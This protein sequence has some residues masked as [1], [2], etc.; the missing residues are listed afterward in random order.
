MSEQEK[1][2]D[3]PVSAT[4]TGITNL[5][6]KQ[7]RIGILDPSDRLN[8]KKILITGSSSGLGLATAI[9][10]A[11]LG[12]VVIMAVRSGIPEKM[13]EVKRKSGSD[14]VFIH[15]VDLSDFDS[16]HKLVN[17]IK[18]QYGQLDVVIC[19]AA[20]VAKKGRKTKHGQEQMF[21]INYLAKFLFINLLLKNDCINTTGPN[22]SRIIFVASES[23]RNPREFNWTDFGKYIPHSI[24]KTVELYG[25]YKLLLV[26]F[27]H[28][29]SH[30]LN[31][32][33]TNIS[34][35]SLCPGPVNS[36]IAREA[37]AIFK[38]LLKLV[39]GI[40]FRSPKKAS[41]PLVYL[42]ASKDVEGK[43]FDYLF[44]MERK[45][46]DE[47]ASDKDNGKKLWQLSEELLGALGEKI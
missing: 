21:T 27:A 23:H 26:S 39:F 22:V 15:N 44:L 33:K 3:N 41:E 31:A 43:P 18:I 35:F 45:T 30:R 20:I 11:K 40:F 47:K 29:L 36:N 8:G 2:Y 34:V 25:Y 16:I 1:K 42:T 5:F 37:P 46:I 9:E 32:D 38:P 10:L 17:E 7:E 13:E 14:Q 12:A 24:G 6:K 19:N 4:L 28:E